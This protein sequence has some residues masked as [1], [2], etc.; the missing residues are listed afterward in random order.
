[1]SWG[2]SVT[3]HGG[4]QVVGPSNEQA[5]N[6]NEGFGI[7]VKSRGEKKKTQCKLADLL[8]SNIVN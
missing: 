8:I 4:I 3:G 5:H 2:S 6:D 7:Q 1:M